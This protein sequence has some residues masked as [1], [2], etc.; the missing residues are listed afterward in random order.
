M[1]LSGC[2]PVPR[3]T[4]FDH[5][6]FQR[7]CRILGL[8]EPY[9]LGHLEYLWRV[10]YSSGNPLIGDDVDVEI[11]AKWHGE[12]GAL[13][14]ALIDPSVR[15]LDAAADGRY[16]IHDLHDNAPEY[17]KD[18][19]R[20]EQERKKLRRQPRPKHVP[21]KSG[22]VS[23][24]SRTVRDKSGTP[25]PLPYQP[26]K[27]ADPD[28]PKG[29]P[30]YSAEPENPASAPNT[31]AHQSWEAQPLVIFPTVGEPRHWWFMQKQ[32][33]EWATAYP[34]VDILGEVRRALAWVLA[35][36]SHQKTAGGMPRFLVGWL[37]KANDSPRRTS[38]SGNSKTSGNAAALA[39]FAGRKP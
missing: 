15:L 9:V 23:D 1:S 39:N 25:V 22:T 26:P 34:S 35:N 3:P 7:L 14:H 19:W 36:R 29:D 32:L 6:K 4:L 21:D 24:K 2:V 10:A 17:V 20:K 12:N 28:P 37:N 31:E 30:E 11:A 8:P 13:V 5:P 27:G 38:S 33:D 16:A 18:R